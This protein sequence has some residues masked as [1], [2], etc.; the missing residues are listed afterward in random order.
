MAEGVSVARVGNPRAN[1]Q[2]D[3][4]SRHRF[5]VQGVGSTPVKLVGTSRSGRRLLPHEQEDAVA[6]CVEASFIV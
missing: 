3:V 5:I 2:R 1:K 4:D 6:V